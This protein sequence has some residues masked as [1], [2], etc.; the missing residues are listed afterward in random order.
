MGFGRYRGLARAILNQCKQKIAEGWTSADETKRWRG[1]LG[2]ALPLAKK[3]RGQEKYERMYAHAV[4][5]PDAGA[6]AAREATPA[7]N[8]CLTSRSKDWP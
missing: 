4:A 7:I 3:Y 8:A 5:A 6:F 2:R 1:I